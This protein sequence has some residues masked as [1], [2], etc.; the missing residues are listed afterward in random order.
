MVIM[1]NQKLKRI[2][3]SFEK[4]K[5]RQKKKSISYPKKILFFL[6]ALK[7]DGIKI[8]K[9]IKIYTKLTNQ[10]CHQIFRE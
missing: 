9:N 2:S 7:S 1:Q 6:E 10:R 5:K 3:I 8:S 4:N